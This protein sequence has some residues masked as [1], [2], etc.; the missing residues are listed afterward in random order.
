MDDFKTGGF[1]SFLGEIQHFQICFHVPDT[2][3]GLLNYKRYVHVCVSF[4]CI[5]LI[6]SF[7]LS[8]LPSLCELF[9][10]PSTDDGYWNRNV[11]VD[12]TS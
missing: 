3:L 6:Y 5:F 7:H 9:W 2:F 10:Y 4:R 12:F 1:V 11:N 8:K